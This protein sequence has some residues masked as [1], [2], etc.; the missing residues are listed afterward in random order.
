VLG[1]DANLKVWRDRIGEDSPS[2]AVRTFDALLR[3]L[4]GMPADSPYRFVEPGTRTALAMQGV[5]QTFS[6]WSIRWR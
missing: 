4:H 6:T 1:P 3:A 2:S 5:H